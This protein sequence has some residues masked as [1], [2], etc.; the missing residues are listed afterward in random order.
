MIVKSLYNGKNYFWVKIPR[1][2]T[3]SYEQ[4]FLKEFCSFENAIVHNH[5]PFFSEHKKCGAPKKIHGGFS[6]VRNPTTRFISAMKY[7]S[8]Q[9]HRTE[10][11]IHQKNTVRICEFCREVTVTPLEDNRD[12]HNFVKFF[13]NENTFYDLLYSTFDKNCELKPGVTLADAFQTKDPAFVKSMFITQTRFSYHPSVK[14]FKY[15]NL[16]EFNSWVESF[17][18][19][20]TSELKQMNSSKDGHLTIDVSTTK[21]KN[22]V[23]HLYYDDFKVFGY[24]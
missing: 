20:D 8:K 5:V 14:I 24:T 19:Y 1:T 4:L 13:D 7:L 10:F 15:E 21:F 11:P 9:W 16:P 22:L 12:K 3:V 6:V 17:L 18:G 23:K 2:G